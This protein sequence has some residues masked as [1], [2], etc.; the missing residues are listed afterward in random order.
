MKKTT[1]LKKGFEKILKDDD[2]IKLEYS[3]CENIQKIGKGGF[4][5]VYSAVYKGEMVALKRL[6]SEEETKEVSKEF[7][8]ELKQLLAINAHPNINE[9]RGITQDNNVHN[10]DDLTKTLLKEA[11]MLK[12]RRPSYSSSKASESSTSSV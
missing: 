5:T 12:P 7:I 8:K 1:I 2:I 6:D 9:F 11:S 3:L 10:D 4:G